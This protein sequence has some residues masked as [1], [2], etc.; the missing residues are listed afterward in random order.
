MKRLQSIA[1]QQERSLKAVRKLRSQEEGRGREI[2]REI[3]Q[4]IKINVDFIVC[5]I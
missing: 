2:E 1:L 3:P 4:F 5:D